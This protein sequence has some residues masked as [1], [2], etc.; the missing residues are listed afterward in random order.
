[1]VQQIDIKNLFDNFLKKLSIKTYPDLIK[2]VRGTANKDHIPEHFIK[3]LFRAKYYL[4]VNKDGT[5]R[6]DITQLP[7]THFKQK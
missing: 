1:M 6:Y 2:G 3:G 4:C 5:I 7:I